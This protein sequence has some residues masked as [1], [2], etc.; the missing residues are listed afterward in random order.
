MMNSVRDATSL[1]NSQPTIGVLTDREVLLVD[2]VGGKRALRSLLL[3]AEAHRLSGLLDFLWQAEVTTIWVWPAT[4]LSRTVTCADLEQAHPHWEVVVH[5]HPHETD[6]PICALLWPRESVHRGTRRLVLAFPEH[7]GWGW[8][9]SDARSLL[10]TVTYLDQVLGRPL[11]D[12]PDLVAHQLLTELAGKQSASRLRAS[13]VDLPRE[14][15]AQELVWRRPLTLV[16]QRERYLHKYAHLSLALE[17]GRSLRLGVGEAEYS[18]NGRAYD[19]RRPGIWRTSTERAGSVFDGR[20]LPS[21]LDGEWMSTSQIQCYRDIGYQ[22]QVREGYCWH[23]WQEVL[24]GWATTLWQAGERLHTDSQRFRHGQARA[25]ASQTITRLANLGVTILAREPTAGGWSRP[26]WWA[27]LLG[28]SRA[29]L[30]AHLVRLVR[31]GTMPVLL[32]REALWVVSNDPDPL[33]AVPGLV[34]ARSWQGYAVGYADPLP[35]ASEVREAFRTTEDAGQL[36]QMLDTLA[37]ESFP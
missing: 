28:S 16:E 10:A 20:R 26:E 14:E 2:T 1:K 15:P 7:A 8:E 30:F 22:V 23:D 11:Y 32:A 21:G 6:R 4:T 12:A 27:S 36:V 13:P 17:A 19:G 35:L 29:A 24:K 37:R 25:N 5:P 9:L 31:K 34:T 3:S 33:T 18:P